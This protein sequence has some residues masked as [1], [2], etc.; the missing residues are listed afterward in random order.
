MLGTC[1][2]KQF[3]KPQSDGFCETLQRERYSPGIPAVFRAK[4]VLLT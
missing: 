2:K 4:Y 1:V 3:E